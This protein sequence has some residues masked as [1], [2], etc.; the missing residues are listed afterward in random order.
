MQKLWLF[1][2]VAVWAFSPSL[3]TAMEEKHERLHVAHGWARESIGASPNGAAFV[4]IHNPTPQ[5]D[6]LISLS[7]LVAERAELHTHEQTNGGVMSM[8]HLTELDVPAGAHIEFK[9]GEM[10]VMLVKL[11]KPLEPGTTIDI[12]FEFERSGAIPVE[13]PVLSLMQ[14]ME[15]TDHEKQHLEHHKK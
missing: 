11:K 8:V 15:R 10:H 1:A 14:S 9:P 13:I 12:T 7:T 5:D 3:A 2:I 6:R 4:V